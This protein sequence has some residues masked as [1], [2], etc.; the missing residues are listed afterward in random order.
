MTYLLD[1]N[2]CI[3]FLNLRDTIVKR[4]LAAVPPTELRLCAIVKAELYDGAHRSSYR[5][6]NLE[7]L[8][9]FFSQFSSIPFDDAIAEV[10]GR[11]RA[12]LANNG[13]LIG[14]NDLMIGAIAVAH[15]LTL[16]AHNTP[17]FSRIQGL[18]IEDWEA[19]AT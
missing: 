6:Q 10:Y 7:L 17:E 19:S 5:E 1:T 18:S 8:S 11:V 14:P 16:V 2:T 4:Q 12:S 9:N 3:Q 15:N 13:N